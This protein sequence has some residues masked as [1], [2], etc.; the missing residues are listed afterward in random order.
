MRSYT[1]LNKLK[2]NIMSDNL[3]RVHGDSQPVFAID[4]RNGPVAGTAA[5]AGVTT[6]FI[7]P[8]FQ[9]FSLDL[10]AALTTQMNIGGAV[11][12]A[13]KCMTQLS[14]IQMYQV[15]AADG[16]MSVC[17]YPVGAWTASDLQVALR[18]LGTVNG[19]VFTG[20]ATAVDVGFKLAAS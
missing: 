16:L 2:G 19:H 11:E 8:A 13:I 1:L 10:G 9:F 6:N 7:G 20:N 15:E 14:T 12:A 17:L 3:Q 18:A 5:P 4:T